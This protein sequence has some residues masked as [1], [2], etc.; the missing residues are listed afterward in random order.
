LA[1]VLDGVNG[2]F[3][4]QALFFERSECLEHERDAKSSDQQPYRQQAERDGDQRV[5]P[6][7][8]QKV[9]DQS[10][11]AG[12]QNQRAAVSDQPSD[13]QNDAVLA[14]NGNFFAEFGLRKF[15][16]LADQHLEFLTQV[17]QQ[18][19]K[20]YLRNRGVLH[21]LLSVAQILACRLPFCY[22]VDCP[23]CCPGPT[24]GRL[25]R[26]HATTI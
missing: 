1:I 4:R 25:T 26:T 8:A 17:A 13:G 11:K 15:D 18:A 21:N 14:E 5:Q 6:S 2:L 20:R 9:C 23:P 19:E 16:L 22:R 7:P 10:S 3:R 12:Q 24:G